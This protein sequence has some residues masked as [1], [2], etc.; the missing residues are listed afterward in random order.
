MARFGIVTS[1][2]YGVSMPDIRNIAKATEKNHELAQALWDSDI[3]EAR[4]LAGLLDKPEWVT[5][6]QMDNWVAEF[7]SWDVCDQI[8]GNLFDRTPYVHEKI[9]EWSQR[10]EEFVKRA[11]FA[12]IAWRAVHDKKQSDKT[13]LAYFPVVERQSGDSRNFVRK[14]VNWA[15]RQI[16][17]RSAY[18]HKPALK[19]ATKLS[20]SEDK[21]ARWIGSDAKKELESEKMLQRLGLSTASN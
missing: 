11:G 2:A 17:K 5:P 14:A 12:M 10:P 7:N 20:V 18:L 13:F 19:L 21:T 3:H 1:K 9:L 4:I 8:C 16:G 15:L 6:E